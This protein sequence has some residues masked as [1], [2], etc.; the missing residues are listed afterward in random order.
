MSMLVMFVILLSL[1]MFPFLLLLSFAGRGIVEHC[2]YRVLARLASHSLF[3]VSARSGSSIE[4]HYI[5]D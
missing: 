4:F 5:P 1:F 3:L 2:A